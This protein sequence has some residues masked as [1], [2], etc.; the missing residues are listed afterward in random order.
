MS[1]P[2]S[3]G[4]GSARRGS[5]NV[6]EDVVLATLYAKG[7]CKANNSGLGGGVIGLTKVTV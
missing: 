2:D 5:E 7:L 4:H 6:R 3:L 1:I